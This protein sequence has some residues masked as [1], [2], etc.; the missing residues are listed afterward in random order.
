MGTY[1]LKAMKE[2]LGD[3]LTPALHDAW[4]AAYQQLAKVM[5][6]REHQLLKEADGW[7][8][9]REFRISQKIRES[10]EITSFHLAPLDGEHLPSYLPGQYISIRI[11]VPELS[12]LQAR[13]YSLSDA[14]HSDYYR[15][16]VKKEPALDLDH[17]KAKAHPGY[18]S[19][20]LHDDAKVGDVLQVS[21]PAGGFFLDIRQDEH[22]DGPIVLISAGVGLTPN[23]SILNTLVSKDTKRKASWVHATR[24]SQ[25]QAFSH[26]IQ[27]TTKFH[28]NIQSHVFNKEPGNGD[29]EGVDYHFKGRMDLNKLDTDHDLFIHNPETEYYICGPQKFMTDIG[30]ALGNWG[31]GPD[32]IKMELFGT[33]EIPVA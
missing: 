14:P 16:S 18:V 11:S 2:V 13:Q 9:W 19:N 30:Q 17:S 7:T 33:G 8:D 28:D 26:H 22:S 21:H 10:S 6:K 25:T 5:I 12:Y 27:E 31:V 15:I 32:R 3:T 24:D 23:L 1:L 29:R 4:A 20:V